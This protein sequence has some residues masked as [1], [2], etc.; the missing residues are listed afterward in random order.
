MYKLIIVQDLITGRNNLGE[1]RIIE[2][3]SLREVN[4][5][6]D[7][8]NERFGSPRSSSGMFI[9]EPN[10]KETL[11]MLVSNKKGFYVDCDTLVVSYNLCD[12]LI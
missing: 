9:W 6:F 11:T 7:D 2:G 3:L 8:F 5:I 10:S 12:Q 4:E 1:N